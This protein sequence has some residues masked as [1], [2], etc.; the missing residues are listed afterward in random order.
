MND[1]KKYHGQEEREAHALAMGKIVMAWNEYHETLGQLFAKLFARNQYG[2]A[3][4]AWQALNNDRAQRTMLAEVAR[5]K[6]KP[7]D[8]AGKEILWLVEKTNQMISDQ[9]NLGIH[10]PLMS[11]TDLDGIHQMLPLTLFGNKRAAS[12][13]GLD[14]L[15]EFAHYETQIRKMTSFTISLQFIVTPKTRRR[16]KVHWPQRPQLAKRALAKRP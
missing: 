6:F 16:G 5:V 1:G 14:L 8:K 11:F 2:L 4:T 9:R 15:A 10:T 3:L 13:H 12:M 7:G